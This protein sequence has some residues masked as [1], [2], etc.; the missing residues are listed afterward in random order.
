MS[1][2]FVGRKHW[3]KDYAYLQDVR[4]FSTGQVEKYRFFQ[5]TDISN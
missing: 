4:R 5:F 3:R 2:R 1:P